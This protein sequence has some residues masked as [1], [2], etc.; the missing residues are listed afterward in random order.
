MPI[1]RK[2]HVKGINLD[3]VDLNSEAL[4]KQGDLALDSNSDKLKYR[5]ATETKEVVNT[6]E[7][8]TLSSKILDTTNTLQY[9]NTASGLTSTTVKEALDE[10]KTGLEAQN[11]ASEIDYTIKL[12]TGVNW[13]AFVDEEV[14]KVDLALDELASRVKANEEAISLDQQALQDHLLETTGAHAASAISVI[15]DGN[16]N[17]ADV[18]AALVELQQDIDSR[19]LT[20]SGLLTNASIETPSR[21]DVK[22][23]TEADL[24]DYAAG[25]GIYLNPASNGQLV[26]ATDTKK[27][28]QVL[29]GVLEPLGA[30][31]STQFE[32]TQVTHG[33]IVG[34]GVYYN[35]ISW[36]KAQAD[37]AATLAT[38]VI[39]EV[40]DVDTFIAA[41]FGR[42][43]VNLLTN[44]KSLAAGSFYYLSETVAGEPTT[45][46]PL[47]YSNPLFYVESLDISDLNNQIAVLQVK[48]YRP[49][50]VVQEIPPVNVIDL[51]AAETINIGDA[52][53]IT[54]AGEVGLL[55]A[56]DDVKMEFIGF[57]NTSGNATDT[58][59]VLL[60]G[61]FGGFIGLTP[62]D[63][64]YA[65]PSI[66]GGFTQTEP[67]ASGVYIIVVGKAISATEIVINPDLA[68]SAEFNS[69][70]IDAIVINNDVTVAT[71]ISG[72]L[73]DGAIYRSV[74]LTYSLY[75]KTDTAAEEASQVGQLRLA[76]KTVDNSW[77]LS[78]DFS[79]DDAGVDFSITSAGQIQYVSSNLVGAN[80]VGS[81]KVKVS[82]IFEI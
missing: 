12:G 40:K 78:D 79:G 65:D 55:D 57:A 59:Q 82:E 1:I 20:D 27:M 17:S 26:F 8:Q 66:P 38:Y 44:P 69:A 25:T 71:S 14:T 23:S 76:Y 36:A 52:L 70:A 60:S 10:L 4:D 19:A 50:A 45:T 47:L 34:E 77:S 58:I 62:G 43:E 56:S 73:F 18:Q 35:G 30:G 33:F 51:V 7:N 2:R 6:N 42:L 16:L 80:H 72:L 74:V 11:E 46:D 37:D 64:L 32:I 21:L 53:Y 31:G 15:P 9:D 54:S 61:K 28:Y 5:N 22:Q 75:R 68:V 41:D 3:P 49:E 67:T 63:F 39:V 24:I 81:L 13:D 48:V 29:D